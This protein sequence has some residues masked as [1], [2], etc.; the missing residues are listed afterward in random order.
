MSKL[1]EAIHY[2]ISSTTP[3]ELGKIKLAKVLFYSDL[4]TFR[5]SG[6]TMTNTVYEKRDRGP[7][8]RGI[9]DCLRELKSGGKIAERNADRYGFTQHQFWSL[10]EPALEGLEPHDVA[11]LN[12]Y[13]RAICENHTAASISELSHNRAWK[14]AQ[15][16]EEI[17]LSA[18]LIASRLSAVNVKE[19]AAF[20]DQLGA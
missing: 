12:V 17:P 14:L 2:V 9:Y 5:R 18:F 1:A 4:D 10:I 11:V 6:R 15:I 19:L 7:M 3:E 16:G 8:P 13:T 20:E